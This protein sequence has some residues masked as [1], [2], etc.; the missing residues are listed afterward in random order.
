MELILAW[1]L[2]SR[3]L[4]VNTSLFYFFIKV[5][6]LN[7]IIFNFII[8]HLIFLVCLHAFFFSLSFIWGYLNH[9]LTQIFFLFNFFSFITKHF[10]YWDF[11]F[12]IFWVCLLCG[13]SWPQSLASKVNM[14]YF[15]S[16]LKLI[17]FNFIL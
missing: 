12:V 11:F 16:F 7:W 5:L 15:F 14:N 10:F 4:K 17:F 1:W 13:W 2:R 3:V 6:L 8:Q 9:R